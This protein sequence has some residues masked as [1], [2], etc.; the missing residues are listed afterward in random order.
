MRTENSELRF[1]AFFSDFQ[2][3]KRSVRWILLKTTGDGVVRGL[4]VAGSELGIRE[5]GEQPQVARSSQST[6]VSGS[7]SRSDKAAMRAAR[8]V[9]SRSSD[10]T[11]P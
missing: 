11:L 9:K 8:P 10:T 2:V 4:D 3:P 6:A 7:F 1:G 5:K